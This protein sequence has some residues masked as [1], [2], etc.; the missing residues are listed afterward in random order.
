[1]SRPDFRSCGVVVSAALGLA[2]P[3]VATAADAEQAT[4]TDPATVG[5]VVVT[6]ER[7]EQ[8]LQRVPVAVTAIGSEMMERSQ[9]RSSQELDVLTPGLLT[10]SALGK[11]QVYIRGVGAQSVVAGA[12][13]PVG[14]YVDGVYVPS[15][16]S[17]VYGF[18]NVE[19]VEVLRGPQGTLFGRNTT[20]GVVQVVTKRPRFDP[21]TS[22]SVT[23]GSYSTWQG[24]LYASTGLTDNVAASI[25]LYGLDQGKGFGRDLNLGIE[26]AYQSE[27]A[28]R[29]DLLF[30]PSEDASLRLSADY[31]DID[32]DLTANRVLLTGAR[33]LGG[34]VRVG[35]PRDTNFTAPTYQNY[36]AWGFMADANMDLGFAKLK[37]ISAYRDYDFNS[38]Y[39]Q[40]ATPASINLVT[41]NSAERT[42]QQEVLLA[43]DTDRLSWTTGVFYLN[44]VAEL[45]P[46]GS[47]GFPN[48]VAS[49][50]DRFASNKITSAAAFAQVTYAV[51]D[52]LKLTA[53]IRYTEDR[54]NLSGT[55][56]AQVG[57]A[58]PVGTVLTAVNGRK[59]KS[60]EPTWR[61]AANYQWTPDIMTYVSVN[62]GYKSG[63]FNSTAI[64]QL[65]TDPETLDAYEAGFKADLLEKRLRLNL[66]VFHYDYDN[67]Q[68]S[69]VA[70]PPINLQTLNA[71]KAR[72]NGGE[73][74]AVGVVPMGDGRLQVSAFLTYLDAKYTSFPSA[75]YFQP[76]PYPAVPPGLNCPTASSTAAGGNTFCTYDASGSRMIRSPKWTLGVNGELTLPV[77]PGELE[78]S[79][80]YYHSD[81]FFWE[82]S[83]RRFQKPYDVINAQVAYAPTDSPWRFRAFVRNLGKEL[84]F[85][86]VSEQASGDLG[87]VAAPRTFGIG[88]DFR[89]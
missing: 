35:G 41:S 53:G 83:N 37:S 78:L 57:N 58:S 89:R 6:A 51:T 69:Q 77:G 63:A 9:I 21:T 27:Y 24:S 55:V 59:L 7:R 20:G 19:R 70:P 75:P 12:E 40:D 64:T 49:T 61:L 71:A 39:D 17:A 67:I 25:A 80:N 47:A 13:S 86:Q 11:S 30:Q 48:A 85:T 8:S 34:A 3:A 4:S 65:P 42:F 88:I 54:S 29:I 74:E 52:A 15:L 50:I 73:F 56:V 76:N 5:E 32:T 18:N 68:L 43:G 87:T 62:H 82:T 46:V 36:V 31:D 66:S 16:S 23:Y 79:A 38:R 14:A 33:G 45:V 1:M 10:S 44:Y 81:G 22:A 26:K 72:Q 2:L 28:G 60:K 84:Y